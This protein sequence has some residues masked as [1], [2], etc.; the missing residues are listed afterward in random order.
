M[1]YNIII[2]DILAQQTYKLNLLYLLIFKIE[3]RCQQCET[4]DSVAHNAQRI[5]LKEFKQ[6]IQQTRYQKKQFVPLLGIID[7]FFKQKEKTFRMKIYDARILQI[8][9]KISIYYLVE[10]IEPLLQKNHHSTAILLIALKRIILNLIMSYQQN[11]QQIQNFDYVL[12]QQNYPL[13]KNKAI[14]LNRN[15]F[16]LLKY[17]IIHKHKIDSIIVIEIFK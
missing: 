14:S 9:L 1:N 6:S 15:P 5:S 16:I 7:G 17:I 4:L 8:I 13:Q 11:I 10:K 3:I 2:R 12:A